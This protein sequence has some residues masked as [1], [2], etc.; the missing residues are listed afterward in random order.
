MTERKKQER[1]GAR[2]QGRGK[3]K[4]NERELRWALKAALGSAAAA[5]GEA[6]FLFAVFARVWLFCKENRAKEK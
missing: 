3:R 4:D 1:R 2:W 6:G 5:A